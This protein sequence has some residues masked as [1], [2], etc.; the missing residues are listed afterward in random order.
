MQYKYFLIYRF[1]YIK[2]II[3]NNLLRVKYNFHKKII[4][5]LQ[6]KYCEIIE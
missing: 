2:K 1:F 5:N 6:N 4:I 3:L